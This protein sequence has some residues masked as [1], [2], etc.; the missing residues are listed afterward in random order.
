[1][2]VPQAV[3]ALGVA[4]DSG[5][6]LSVLEL[7]VTLLLH[8][9]AWVQSGNALLLGALIQRSDLLHQSLQGAV[10]GVQTQGI[11]NG[12]EGAGVVLGLHLAL[13]GLDGGGNLLH[14]NRL[15]QLAA[16]LLQVRVG[17][18]NAQTTLDG[19][20]STV[21]VAHILKTQSATEITLHEVLV[22]NNAL[23][24][25]LGSLLPLLKGSVARA[26]IGK[27]SHI[28]V[29]QGNGLGVLLNGLSI[30]LCLEETVSLAL[31]NK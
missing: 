31:R 10:L 22:N 6:E 13:S 16:H 20:K 29:I 30:L 28:F 15:I 19:L 21:E 26:S 18:V 8:S 23:A 14:A 17:G 12:L 5:L 3:K 9:G 4:L 2:L 27:E 7:G 1:M 11:V 24:A 25:I